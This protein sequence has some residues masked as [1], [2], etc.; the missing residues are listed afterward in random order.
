MPVN[1]FWSSVG[2]VLG[3]LAGV[4]LLQY[5]LMRIGTLFG[6]LPDA[7]EYPIA[8]A[9]SIIV[10]V[11]GTLYYI[12]WRWSWKGEH[13]GLSRNAAA[14]GG[15]WLLGFAAGAAGALVAHAVSGV[16]AAGTL[17][18]SMPGVSLVANPIVLALEL[19]S[20]FV[21]ELV[22]RGASISRLQADL[23]P[24]EVLIAAP[25]VPLGWYLITSI[26]RFGFLPMGIN[27]QYDFAATLFVTLLFLRTDSVWLSAG[28]RMGF[29]AAVSLLTLSVSGLGGG[30][31]WGLGA[32]ILLY[33]EW[34][35]QQHMP[36]RT[37]QR[38]RTTRGPW[39]P[40]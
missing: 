36:R 22:F 38:G 18:F 1:R 15:K 23:T 7:V 19:I 40:H 9:I 39:G 31:V 33:A 3:Y 35:K 5:L 20:L 6:L 11:V 12:D 27:F 26:F 21:A 2:S 25:L 34:S 16:I 32:L 24:R 17:V 37:R 13:I 29:Y 10:P 30:L 4:G 28:L 8:L 14:A